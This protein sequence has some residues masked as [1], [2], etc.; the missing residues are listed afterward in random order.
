MELLPD[1]VPISPILPPASSRVEAQ[2]VPRISQAPQI[3]ASLMQNCSARHWLPIRLVHIRCNAP[4]SISWVPA[5]RSLRFPLSRNRATSHSVGDHTSLL[6]LIERR[7]LTIN[8]V[9]LHLTSRDQFANPLEDL[10]DFNHS[11]SLN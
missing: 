8:D 1:N 5:F 3:P 7:F 6:A 9:R 4:I 2:S 11:P 10:F